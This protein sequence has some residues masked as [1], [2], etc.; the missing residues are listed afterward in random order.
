MFSW[1]TKEKAFE[2][3]NESSRHE[4]SIA[5]LDISP[6]ANLL[7]E[8]SFC[9]VMI[10]ITSLIHLYASV[11]HTNKCSENSNLGA[12]AIRTGQDWF[13]FDRGRWEG[14]KILQC[15]H[16]LICDLR[17]LP[18]SRFSWGRLTRHRNPHS[19]GL[20]FVFKNVRALL[21]YTFV[22]VQTCTATERTEDEDR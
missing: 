6:H 18:K 19:F 9:F 10:L 5:L 11:W 16:G 1:L 15:I 7:I 2:S 8:D 3:S 21:W 13:W 14:A 17:S 22:K 20:S 4:E 12:L